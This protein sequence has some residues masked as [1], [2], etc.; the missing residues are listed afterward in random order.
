MSPQ[1]TRA[2]MLHRNAM[3]CALLVIAIVGISAFLRLSA[4]GLDCSPWPRCYGQVQSSLQSGIIDVARLM[5]RVLAVALLPL[6]L[7]LVM[8]GFARKPDAWEQRWTSVLALAL[9]L[10]LAVLGRW[11]AGA[12]VPAVALG[13]L[14]GGFLLFALCTRMALAGRHPRVN[15]E[16]SAST[17]RW[18]RVAIGAVV[19]QIAL[20]GLVSSSLAGLSCPGFPTC[21]L[22]TPIAWEALN[23]WHVPHVD[24]SIMPIN[25]DGAIAQWL[26]RLVALIAALAVAVIAVKLLRC[27][28]RR[29]GLILLAL[30]ALQITLGVLMVLFGLPLAMAIAHN[31]LAAV[32]LATLLA[33]P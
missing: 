6:M 5:H 14:L 32:L 30:L 31:L 28:R 1:N 22:P 13:N 21:A 9:V 15:H 27:G 7:L 19:L 23:P 18:Q 24:P 20:G 2:V 26:H 16:L 3:A 29:T 12:K 17:R 11:T 10:F 25:P 33:V 4:A 8:G